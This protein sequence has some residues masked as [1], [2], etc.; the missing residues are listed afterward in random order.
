MA[1][2]SRPTSLTLTFVHTGQVLLELKARDNKTLAYT[3]L[4]VKDQDAVAKTVTDWA[5]TTFEPG[6][7]RSEY[8][9]QLTQSYD[10]GYVVEVSG[11]NT[12]PLAQFSDASGALAS[13][14]AAIFD[15]G[16]GS[17]D[18]VTLK[19]L[20]TQLAWDSWRFF[21][22]A[23]LKCEQRLADGAYLPILEG[24]FKTMRSKKGASDQSFYEQ[25]ERSTGAIMAA[26]R[27]LLLSQDQQ[28]R[29]AYRLIETERSALYS[30]YME[31]T[32]GGHSRARL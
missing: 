1:I 24:Y 2:Y 5:H 26:E 8:R 27:Y 28:A 20:S 25:W 14:F 11:Q 7:D 30:W 9:D 18:S 19:D 10:R 31:L 32:K 13:R 6:L 15:E 29:R 3:E 21:R 4:P 23:Q 22:T 16:T 17:P 12:A